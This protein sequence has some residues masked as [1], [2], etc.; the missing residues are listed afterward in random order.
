MRLVGGSGS[1]EGRLEVYYNGTWGT[2][3]DSGFTDAAASVVFHMLGYGR[4]GRSAGNRYGAGNGTIWLDEL[5]CNGRETSIA[6]C[7]LRNWTSHNCRHSEDVSVL[8][9][10]V[11]LVGGPSSQEG[12]LEVFHDGIWG[13]VC[14]DYFN[15]VAARVVC[16]MLGYGYFGHFL[17]RSYGAGSGQI[18]LD[19]VQCNGTERNIADCQHNGWGSH[20]CHH[21]EDVS[22]SC[23]TVRL[24]EGSSPL[25]GRLEVRYKATWEL[26]VMI[27][28]IT[29]QQEL[30]A[31]CWDTNT[32]DGLLVTATV[33]VM[34]RFGWMTF[35][36]TER[37]DTSAS[38]HTDNGAFTTVNTMKTCLSPVLATHQ[39]VPRVHHILI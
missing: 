11:R 2:V 7:S 15:D 21:G 1:Q 37:K 4:I 24:V 25:E 26:C 12:R 3:C 31:T 27:I 10:G 13:T 34:E 8:C 38:V 30:F 14:G 39:Q 9:P 29:V 5:Q 36:V 22:V 32:P 18:W 17:S 20:D 16:L 23:V 6:E 19:N 28:L 35:G 33:P